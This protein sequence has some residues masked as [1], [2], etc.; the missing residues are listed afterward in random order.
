[1]TRRLT[2]RLMAKS[3]IG[4]LAGLTLTGAFGS[5][6]ASAHTLTLQE[7]LDSANAY[8]QR[9]VDDPRVPY[10]R[11][12]VTCQYLFPHRTRCWARYDSESTLRTNQWACT[13]QIMV[14]YPAHPTYAVLGGDATHESVPCSPVKLRGNPLSG[15]HRP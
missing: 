6:T 5:A 2:R 10:V 13:E 11:K 9:V 8:A 3:L 1:M 14:H 15:S 7:A 12:W 4:L